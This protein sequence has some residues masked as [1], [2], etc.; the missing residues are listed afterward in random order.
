MLGPLPLSCATSFS[1]T[2]WWPLGISDAMCCG[3]HFGVLKTCTA[4]PGKPSTSIFRFDR[5]F[6]APSETYRSGTNSQARLGSLENYNDL[7]PKR[8]SLLSG[9]LSVLESEQLYIVKI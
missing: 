1:I 4:R 5:A 6:R 2:W 3:P 8:L 9:F 7:T